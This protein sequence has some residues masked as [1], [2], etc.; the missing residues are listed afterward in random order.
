MQERHITE[1]LPQTSSNVEGLHSIDLLNSTDEDKAIILSYLQNTAPDK[2][3]RAKPKNN[4]SQDQRIYQ[5]ESN[6]KPFQ[7]AEN[8][9][10]LSY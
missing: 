1:E 4:P 2:I 10:L 9:R 7:L 5:S 8:H 6:G 3:R